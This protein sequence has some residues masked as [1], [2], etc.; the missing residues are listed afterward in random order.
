MKLSQVV[1]A[2]KSQE[3]ENRKW[4]ELDAHARVIFALSCA[5]KSEGWIEIRSRR[6]LPKEGRYL[7][8]RNLPSNK[9]RPL[10]R[11]QVIIAELV[12]WKRMKHWVADG[13]S[14]RGGSAFPINNVV[15]YRHL[16]LEFPSDR[17]EFDW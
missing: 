1:K 2:W 13:H 12:M 6:D 11:K 8:S 10:I 14:D 4:E 5:D 17:E 9:M 15:A 7:V 3:G 16:P